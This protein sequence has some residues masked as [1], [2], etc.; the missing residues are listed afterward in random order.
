[1]IAP[2]IFVRDRQRKIA[3]NVAALQKFATK[4]VRCCLQLRKEKR[5]D[6]SKLPEVFV[7][8]IS[9][10]RMSQTKTSGSLL[11]SVRFSFRN[12]KQ[13]RTAF[14]ANFWSAATLTAIFR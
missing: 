3:V 2:E 1:M 12:C 11:R 10:R 8:L 7:W 6:L 9:D 13:Q 5:T 14:V 4:A